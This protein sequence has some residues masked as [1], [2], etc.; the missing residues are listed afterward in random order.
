M[1][2]DKMKDKRIFDF[3]ITST[4]RPDKVGDMIPEDEIE[5]A[6]YIWM[7]HDSPIQDMHSNRKIGKGINWWKDNEGKYIARGL[8]YDD[9]QV[10]DEVWKKIQ[11][12][13]Y[14]MVSIGG[15]AF[16]KEKN[17]TGGMDLNDLEILEVS[18]C[19]AGMHPDAKILGYNTVAKSE[20]FILKADIILPY[21]NKA[22][23]GAKE[24][25]P[26]HWT[27][28]GPEKPRPWAGTRP[29]EEKTKEMDKFTE[30]EGK[31][32]EVNIMDIV[33]EVP[34][35]PAAPAAPATVQPVEYATKAEFIALMDQVQKIQQMI[36]ATPQEAKQEVKPE[37]KKPEETEKKVTEIVGKEIEKF[38][39]DFKKS[40]TP[41]PDVEK[42]DVIPKADNPAW[43]VIKGK[44]TLDDFNKKTELSRLESKAA[45]LREFEKARA[46]I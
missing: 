23:E 15:G 28:S 8:V 42:A 29:E 7:L 26:S 31:K 14:K 11:T 22:W 24:P 32:Q 12:K 17:N 40:Y 27:G 38:K 6:L 30:I 20:P 5:E 4:A 25:K 39:A 18:V 43:D 36:S 34:V 46:V 45:Q 35:A 16:D 37:E 9:S 13:E 33:K 1:K 19:Q 41:L 3:V 44:K 2:L 21:E 10:A